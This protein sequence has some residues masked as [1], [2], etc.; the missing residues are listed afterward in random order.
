MEIV[1]KEGGRSISR[2]IEAYNLDMIISVG[3]RVNSQ[4][5]T[6]FRMWATQRLTDHLVQGYT[7]NEDRLKQLKDGFFQLEKTV[8]L[9]QKSGQADSLKIDEAKGL[10]EI[11]SN[12]TRSFILLNQFDSNRLEAEKLTE[13]ITYEI[14]YEE[15]KTAIEELKRQLI[16][17]KE[18]SELFGN[19]IALPDYKASADNTSMQPLKNKQRTYYTSSEKTILLVTV[20]N[21]LVH[22]C[23]FGFWKKTTIGS[24]PPAS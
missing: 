15:A 1:Q 12:Y 14:R 22:F 9:I 4:R 19:L 24:K 23:S 17:K 2:M 7:L 13:N 3:Y 18:A 8:K 5:A 11:I 16:V 20:I 10:L 6:Q 21:E